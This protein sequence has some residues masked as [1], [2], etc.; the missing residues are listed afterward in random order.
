MALQTI[1][2]T[3]VPV[4]GALMLLTLSLVFLWVP[5]DVNL[6]ISQRIL[7]FHVPLALIGFVGFFLVFVGSVLYLWRGAD[8]WDALAVASAEVGV[9]FTTLML[10][11]GSIWAKPVWGTWWTWDPRLTTSFVMWMIYVGY[12]LLRAYS[13]AGGQGSRYAA[14]LGIVAFINVPIVYMATVWW[15]TIHP[16][17]VVGPAAEAGGMDER[18]GAALMV[19]MAAFLLLFAYLVLERYALRT[20]EARVE[21]LHEVLETR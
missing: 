4:T 10:V 12:L 17:Q 13:P 21:R 9:L 18:M 3:L 19:S 14:I 6:G 8:R 16:P 5:T 11:T 20:D 2:Q 7:Y 15:R 1:K